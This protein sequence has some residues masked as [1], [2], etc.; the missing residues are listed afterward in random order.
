MNR[1]FRFAL[2]LALAGGLASPALA[3][4][5]HDRG[6]HDRHRHHDDNRDHRKHRPQARRDCP[7]GLVWYQG[8]CLRKERFQRQARRY[9]P[10]VG[11]RFR[12]DAYRRIGDPG[13]YALQQN[14][15]WNYYR[16]DDQIYRVDRH[17]QK[18]LAV[19]QLLQALS[20]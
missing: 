17:T 8:E 7:P 4:H 13:L 16:D 5:D 12:P 3:E 2:L 15:D 10:R 9:D 6:R 19:L 20:N 18:V 14:A 1:P 11:D